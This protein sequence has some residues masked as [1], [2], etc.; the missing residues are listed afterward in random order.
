MKEN[1]LSFPTLLVRFL[2]AIDRLVLA[3][4]TPHDNT[5]SINIAILIS[6]DY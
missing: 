4:R 5:E 6:S 1:V 3:I 2:V